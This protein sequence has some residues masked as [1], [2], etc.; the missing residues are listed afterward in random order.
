MAVEHFLGLTTMRRSKQ[1]DVMVETI[2]S[3]PRPM[4][5]AKALLRQHGARDIT[6][7]AR[8]L[9]GDLLDLL[10]ERG[11]LDPAFRSRLMAA[12]E[13]A[14]AGNWTEPRHAELIALLRS[15]WSPWADGDV[16]AFK[17]EAEAVRRARA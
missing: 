12:R 10:A 5:K 17:A 2:L 3:S 1:R 13:D 4:A 15:S 9:D 6:V 16:K 14:E 7:S 8:Q 11:P